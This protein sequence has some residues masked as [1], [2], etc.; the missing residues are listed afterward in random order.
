M[1]IFTLKEISIKVNYFNYWDGG[2]VAGRF[3]C[4]PLSV[5]NF[6]CKVRFSIQGP[7]CEIV[8]FNF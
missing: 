7:F 3:F 2:L 8:H 4:L 1:L 6:V 5:F